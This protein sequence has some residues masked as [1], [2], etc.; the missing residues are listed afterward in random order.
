LNSHFATGAHHT[1]GNF[2]TIGNEYLFHISVC[3]SKI[4]LWEW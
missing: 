4:F 1:K 3:K 2:T